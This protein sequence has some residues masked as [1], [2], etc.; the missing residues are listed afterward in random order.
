MATTE[1][2]PLYR[3]VLAAFG[4]AGWACAEVPGREVVHAGFE[5][6]HGRVELHVQ[7]FEPLGAVSVVS[8]SAFHDADPA[9]RDRLAE[10]AMRVNET[11]TVG[12]FELV[13]DS[14]RLVFRA[15]NLFSSPEGDARLVQ[16]MVQTAVVEMDRIAPL[17]AAIHRASGPELAALPIAR[18]VAESGDFVEAP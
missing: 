2:S 14:G 17:A 7:V 4:G 16:G 9:R 5:A 1:P 18:M 12:N 13:W 3:T 10:L 8:E 11:L 15:T 6:H